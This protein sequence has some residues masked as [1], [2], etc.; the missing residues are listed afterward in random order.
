MKL[1]IY[2]LHKI[3][4]L[5]K[6]KLP[7]FFK[8]CNQFIQ[9]FFFSIFFQCL[10]ILISIYIFDHNRHNPILQALS[11]KYQSTSSTVSV[12]EWMSTLIIQVLESFFLLFQFHH[13]YVVFHLHSYPHTTV[14]LLFLFLNH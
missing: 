7:L 11:K 1:N 2:V 12:L 14:A 3:F 10:Q 6:I 8:K 13:L 4:A 9:T 5:L